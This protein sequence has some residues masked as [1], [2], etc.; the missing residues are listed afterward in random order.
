MAAW[1]QA[2]RV[3]G[4]KQGESKEKPITAGQ[5]LDEFKSLEDLSVPNQHQIK[6]AKSTLRMSDAGAL[7]MGGMT[8]EE[9]RRVLMDK[10]GWSA[11][12]VRK[13]EESPNPGESIKE[14]AINEPANIIKSFA[15]DSGKSEEEVEKLWK[16]A[17]EAA[18]K[19][20][21]DDYYAYAVGVLKKMLK[22]ESKQR[23][24]APHLNNRFLH[25]WCESTEKGRGRLCTTGC[26]TPEGEVNMADP[27]PYLVIEEDPMGTGS[28]IDTEMIVSYQ[29][30]CPC[31]K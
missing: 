5:F 30:E 31:Y 13:F 19:A 1:P 7:V 24:Y 4:I 20:D 21:T 10:L 3:F 9:A 25:H 6:I 29:D 8:K 28:D 26:L 22:L 14:F 12:R 16:E 27:C 17:K 2:I 23:E 18:D 15:Q 11:E